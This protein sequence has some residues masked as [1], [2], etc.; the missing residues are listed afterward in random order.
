LITAKNKEQQSE[1]SRT[2]I[3]I[4]ANALGHGGGMERYVSD[5]VRGFAANGTKPIF[6]TRRFDMSLPE[7]QLVERRHI[8]TSFLPSKL[9]DHWFSRGLRAARR[10]AQVDVLIGCNRVDTADIAVCGGT[11][12]GFLRATGRKQKRS[13]RWQI[14]L[15]R[16]SY[17]RA[18]IV[19][20]HSKQMRSELRELYDVEDSKIRVLYPP[21]DSARFTPVDAAT[22]TTLRQKY[23]FADDEVVLLFPSR[24]HE[25]KG[26]PMIERALEGTPMRVVLAVAGR[27]PARTSGRVRYLGFLKKIEECYQAADFTILASLYEPFGMAGVE[28][29]MCGTPAILSSRVG[30]SEVI[31][32]AAKFTFT[33]GDVTD[34]RAAIDRAMRSFRSGESVS[35][36]DLLYN[37]SISNHTGSVLSLARHLHCGDNEVL[38]GDAA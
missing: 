2:R 10:M 19:V 5:L 30:C 16:R 21:V 1:Q 32:P 24:S 38:V 35:R 12:L 36:A 20:A 33:P 31:A 27:A 29:V 3:G 25:R 17:E 13:D 7:S 9:R 14:A 28:T 15:E 23:G 11:H 18:K 34:L 37:T 22:R 26:L 6:F 4:S 8:G